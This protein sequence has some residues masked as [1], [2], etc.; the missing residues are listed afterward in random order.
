MT[1]TLFSGDVSDIQA[2][3]ITS[4]VSFRLKIELSDVNK[5]EVT[6][7]LIRDNIRAFLDENGGY[8]DGLLHIEVYELKLVIYGDIYI[9]VPSDCREFI[10][11]VVNERALEY[12]Q[13]ILES[14]LPIRE[15]TIIKL[16]PHSL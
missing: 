8:I 12:I 1:K 4:D 10:Q 2:D 11:V 13:I 3:T 7:Q 6:I 16:S 14:K 15:C 9:W 5:G